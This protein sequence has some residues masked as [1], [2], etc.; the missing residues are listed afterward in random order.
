MMKVEILL[1]GNE[2]ELK[3]ICT[4]LTMLCFDNA[5]YIDFKEVQEEEKEIQIPKIF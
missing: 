3:E 4:E 5:K 1:Q 2:E